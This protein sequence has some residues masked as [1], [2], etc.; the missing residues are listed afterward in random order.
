M[1][2]TVNPS[3]RVDEVGRSGVYPMSGPLPA[4]RARIVGQGQLGQPPRH[5]RAAYPH[6]AGSRDAILNV[7]RILYGGFF[8][9]NGIS[10]FVN[11]DSMVE[12]ARSKNVPL[13]RAA[14]LGSGALLV[15]G[16]LSLA[17]GMR[18]K[19]GAALVT[20]FL[21]G[22]TPKMHDF[23]TVTDGQQRTN[24]LINFTKNL[25]LLGGAAFAASVPE[26]WPYSARQLFQRST[27]A[28]A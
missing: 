15:L 2:D 16:G 4:G 24:E 26:P 3:T 21:A 5:G 25:A 23:W 22:V 27:P 9:Y 8:L 18:P 6:V 7:G 17:T 20:T 19:V 1:T 13:P 10:H 11:R 14:V 12:Y 28:V